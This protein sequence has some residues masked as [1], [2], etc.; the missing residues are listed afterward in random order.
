MSARNRHRRKE[1]LQNEQKIYWQNRKRKVQTMQENEPE[2]F[3]RYRELKSRKERSC[4]RRKR[5]R[6][7][8]DLTGFDIVKFFCKFLQMLHQFY[9]QEY[10]ELYEDDDY[11]LDY[12]LDEAKGVVDRESDFVYEVEEY[13]IW[14][15]SRNIFFPKKTFKKIEVLYKGVDR[16]IAFPMPDELLHVSYSLFVITFERLMPIK[17]HVASKDYGP[18]SYRRGQITKG[19]YGTKLFKQQYGEVACCAEHFMEKEDDG[20]IWKHRYFHDNFQ[21]MECNPIEAKKERDQDRNEC[22][23]AG[24]NY[25]PMC[26][27]QWLK[28]HF[29]LC[30]K[31]IAMEMSIELDNAP[32]ITRKK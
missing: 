4:R 14:M 16:F 8:S 17:P 22:E 10:E 3:D 19:Y 24:F 15:T 25:F 27:S 2:E 30:I 28:A 7:T 18:D 23:K 12:K 32:L 11:Y 6:T 31:D 29:D 5:A 26:L 1:V 20:Y 13:V 9:L 21:I